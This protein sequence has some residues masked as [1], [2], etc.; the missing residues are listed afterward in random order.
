MRYSKCYDTSHSLLWCGTH[1][2]PSHLCTGIC[3][4]HQRAALTRCSVG[5]F[6]SSSQTIPRMLTLVQYSA[7]AC[8]AMSVRKKFRPTKEIPG[9]LHVTR[10][11]ELY[12]V[13]AKG[14]GTLT[15]SLPQFPFCS[16][17]RHTLYVH[18]T[19]EISLHGCVIPSQTSN[20]HQLYKSYN[21]IRDDRSA[22]R[23]FSAA[24]AQM[25]MCAL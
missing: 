25:Y 2:T 24:H 7:A 13:F 21:S 15:F 9:L 20:P 22:V 3:V 16:W 14:G 23:A 5:L 18:V 11:S 17:L 1:R 10:Y 12:L 19:R 8:L 6:I 4:Y